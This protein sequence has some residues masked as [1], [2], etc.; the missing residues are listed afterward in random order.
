MLWLPF[1]RKRKDIPEGLWVRCEGCK[2]PVY[3]KAIEDN[4]DV[5][6]ECQF[7]F[8]IGAPRRIEITLDPGSFVE[9]DAGLETVDALGFVAKKSYRDKLTE[10]QQATGL[11]EAILAG[12]GRIE[13]QPVIFGAMDGRFIKGSMGAVVGE[14]VARAAER[15]AAKRLPLV[16]FAASGGARMMEGILSLMQMAKTA[17]TL[18]RLEDAGGLFVSVLTNPTTAGVM[19]SFATLG[20]VILAEPGALIGFTGPR[21][22]QQTI[23][24]SL[25]AGFQRSEFLLDHG[26]IDRVVPRSKMREELARILRYCAP[27]IGRRAA[28]RA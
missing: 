3:R 11:R 21:V 7:H 8:D 19:A 14:K 25:P 17:A 5:C 20:D 1:G 23:R 9:H 28:A 18:A 13:G 27:G 22:I 6:P 12:D 16:L 4:L 10:D 24:A 15:A 2:K 26:F